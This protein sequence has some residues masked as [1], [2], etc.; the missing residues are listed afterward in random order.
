MVRKCYQCVHCSGVITDNARRQGQ[1]VRKFKDRKIIG[2]WIP[3]LICP[4]VPAS[5]IINYY[6][7][8]TQEYFYTKVLGLPYVGGGNKV[9]QQQIYQNLTPKKHSHP[10]DHR[11]IIGVDT[12]VDCRYVIGDAKGIFRF[13]QFGLDA[14]RQ[15]CLLMDH[16]SRAI[17]FIDQGGDIL[18]ARK[19]RKKYPGRVFLVHY[20]ADHKTLQLVKWGKNDEAG[21]V[22]VD[23]NRMIQLVVDEFTD[24]RLKL[25]YLESPDEWYEYWLHFSHIYRTVEMNERLERNV[26]TWKRSDRDDWVHATVYYRTGIMRFGQK[27]AIVRNVPKPE[28]NSYEILPGG[29]TSRNPLQKVVEAVDKVPM[30]GG[31]VGVDNE[32]DE[33]R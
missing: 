5:E 16:W 15:L 18:M 27:G 14:E 26:Y 10:A 13:G 8:K 3:L 21:A 32:D 29:R 2:F 22:Q 28:P 19:L 20:V 12:G 6:E 4:W 7:N 11:V 24:K 23:R 30:K 1:W 33:W 31:I 9:V 25:Y 17:M